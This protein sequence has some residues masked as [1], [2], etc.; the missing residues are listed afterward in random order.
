M[1]RCGCGS[2]CGCAVTAGDNVV[3]T[4]SGTPAVPWTVTALTDCDEVRQCLTSGSG[5]TY[6]PTDGSFDVCVSPNAGNGLTQDANGCLYVQMGQATVTTGCGILG[7]GAPLDPVR[8]S[9][10]TW[11]FACAP[12]AN[13][14]VIACDAN[15]VLKGE[16]PYHTYYFQSNQQQFFAANPLVPNPDD[17][18][19]LTF[20]FAVTNEDPC[21]TMRIVMW[22]DADVDFN[23][24]VNS[25][26]A[27]GLGT[28]EMVLV[29][30][31]G[32]AVINDRHTQTGKLTQPFAA[33]APGATVNVTVP[34]TMGKGGGGATYNRI[35]GTMSGILL[36]V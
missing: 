20:T 11:P 12:E 15:G 2:T 32:N 28:D 30:N 17:T 36:P 18:P 33:V 4:G 22:I 16:P 5:T 13:G 10:S 34:V 23:L 27:W 19:V 25:T 1:A 3:I 6:D 26:A 31:T 35:Q 29:R 14:S 7:T 24:P 21:R 9:V 8:A